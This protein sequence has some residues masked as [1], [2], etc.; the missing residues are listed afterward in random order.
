MTEKDYL[1]P[2]DSL[3]ERIKYALS[4]IGMSQ[5]D[6]AER[7]GV[8]KGAVN[9]WVI[10]RARSIK[11][12]LI[13]KVA[14]ELGVDPLWLATGKG[15]PTARANTEIPE[16]LAL[17]VESLPH[18][19]SEVREL[20]QAVLDTIARHALG[21]PEAATPEAQPDEPPG[22]DYLTAAYEVLDSEELRDRFAA[23]P[24]S[25]KGQIVAAFCAILAE[26]EKGGSS[27]ADEAKAQITNV[28]DFYRH[29]KIG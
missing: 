15:D 20:A 18:M 12:E 16:E 28:I 25:V 10:G 27:N 14:R 1:P 9:N 19:R 3:A 7:V 24:A 13:T 2:S 23:L 22:A 17:I 11:T 29:V 5:T 26:G 8:T 6:L 4:R 21:V